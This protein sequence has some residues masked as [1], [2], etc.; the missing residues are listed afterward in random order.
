MNTLTRLSLT[1]LLFSSGVSMLHSQST[2]SPEPVLPVVTTLDTPLTSPEAPTPEPSPTPTLIP[3]PS[4]TPLPIPTITSTPVPTPAPSSTPTR[5]PTPLASAL[6][7]KGYASYPPEIQ[8]LVQKCI[9]LSNQGLSYQF[10]SA[11][12]AQGGMDC[13][14]TIMHLLKSAG[15]KN[16]PRQSDGFYRWTW[17][18]DTFTAVNGMTFNSFEW[19]K[20]KP[21]DLLFWVGTYGVDKKR[22]PAISHVMLYLGEEVSTG[23][24]VMFGASENRRYQDK[25]R[26]GVGIFDFVLPKSVNPESRNQ[27][28]MIGY[29]KI[30]KR[31]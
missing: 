26:S 1:L 12:P 24:R 9:A 8:D 11:D 28:R 3:A 27:P 30:P 29:G 7:L 2:A 6:Q 22:D 23:R 20:L 25:R 5:A 17:Q 4:A 10:G 14:G 31:S 21:G 18:N 13:S 15:W 19:S 16:L